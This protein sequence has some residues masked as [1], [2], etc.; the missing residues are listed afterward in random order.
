M[1]Y[2]N[3][4]TT[5]SAIVPRFDKGRIIMMIGSIFHRMRCLSFD[6][7]L[8]SALALVR[9]PDPVIKAKLYF[10]LDVAGEIV[11]R[12][13]ELYCECQQLVV[14]LPFDA[15]VL[16]RRASCCQERPLWALC[17]PQRHQRDH[18]RQQDAGDDHA[19]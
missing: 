12:S 11:R 15:Y 14:V 16:L 13:Q 5:L 17:E 6:R 8:N 1:Y 7:D 19:D 2:L 18:H 4:V 10:L 3:P 9:V